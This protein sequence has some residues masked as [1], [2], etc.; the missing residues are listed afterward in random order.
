MQVILRHQNMVNQTLALLYQKRIL[1]KINTLVN[2]PISRLFMLIIKIRLTKS[3][4]ILKQTRLELI[5]NLISRRTAVIIHYHLDVLA[6]YLNGKMQKVTAEVRGKSLF[7]I[8]DHNFIIFKMTSRIYL[9]NYFSH[10]FD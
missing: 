4:G 6:C 2:L 3:Q 5:L 7:I 1:W 8:L 10:K 9:N